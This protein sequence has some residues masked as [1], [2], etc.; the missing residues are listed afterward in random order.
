MIQ[1][2]ALTAV[3]V[4]VVLAVELS[5]K[6]VE[7]AEVPAFVHPQI[8]FVTMAMMPAVAAVT[9]AEPAASALAAAGPAVER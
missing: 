3:A 5:A 1:S 6:T 8:A 2:L 4:V 9:S 7:S